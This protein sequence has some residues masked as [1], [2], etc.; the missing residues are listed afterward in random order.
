MGDKVNLPKQDLMRSNLK[1]DLDPFDLELIERAFESA[2]VMVK[3]NPTLV[4]S[5]TATKSSKQLCGGS[6]LKLPWFMA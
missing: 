1:R 6:S 2:Q 5:S 3:D 4:T